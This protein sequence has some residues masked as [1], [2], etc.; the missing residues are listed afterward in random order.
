MA[1]CLFVQCSLAPRA[2]AC[3][4]VCVF[5]TSVYR[6][7]FLKCENSYTVLLYYICKNGFIPFKISCKIEC[8]IRKVGIFSSSGPVY[9]MFQLRFSI[10]SILF[11]QIHLV[12]F[13][14]FYRCFSPFLLKRCRSAHS[15]LEAAHKY[16]TV[17]NILI[18]VF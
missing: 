9:V 16:D 18:C 13:T 5:S 3:V 4:C 12:Q 14:A 2:Y 8:I 10:C 17:T 6:C 11:W 7:R 15:E 1:L